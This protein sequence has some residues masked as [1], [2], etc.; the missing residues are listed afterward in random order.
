MQKAEKICKNNPNFIN[1]QDEMKRL[2]AKTGRKERCQK[3][4]LFRWTANRFDV[5]DKVNE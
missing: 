2:G 1:T 5:R 3:I 4:K